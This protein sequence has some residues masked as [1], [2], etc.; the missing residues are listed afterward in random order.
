MGLSRAHVM[1]KHTGISRFARPSRPP[2]LCDLAEIRICSTPAVVAE[3]YKP[4]NAREKK[5]GKQAMRGRPTPKLGTCASAAAHNS[6]FCAR[7]DVRPEAPKANRTSHVHSGIRT[8]NH[9]YA[10]L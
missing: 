7:R 10:Q 6:P 5:R 2:R 1:P 3:H 4:Q 8:R 9:S